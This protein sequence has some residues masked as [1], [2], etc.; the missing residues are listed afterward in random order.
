MRKLIAYFFLAVILNV[1]LFHPLET[2]HTNAYL[3]AP[4]P[5][6]SIAEFVM[7]VCLNIPD[8]QPGDERETE[9]EHF[10][11][12]LKLVGGFEIM[13]CSII[14]QNLIIA[15]LVKISSAVSILSE[16]FISINNPPPEA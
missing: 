6:N 16:T 15:E 10:S 7:E 14:R 12:G 4:D 11:N 13:G 2:M 3:S 8:T 1:V 5:I 9:S